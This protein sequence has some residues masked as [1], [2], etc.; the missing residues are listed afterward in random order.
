M[1]DEEI[2][3]ALIKLG[4]GDGEVGGPYDPI[5]LFQ[6]VHH[7]KVDGI[8]GEATQAEIKKALKDAES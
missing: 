5:R 1:T 6:E 7:L 8:A 3:N 2:R 4:Y